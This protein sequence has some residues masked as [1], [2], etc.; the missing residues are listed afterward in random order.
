MPLFVDMIDME[1]KEV[2]DLHNLRP[3]ELLDSMT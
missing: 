1:E 2:E 3:T